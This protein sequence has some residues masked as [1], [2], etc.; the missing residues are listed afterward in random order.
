MWQCIKMKLLFFWFGWV[1]SRQIRMWVRRQRW[2]GG[3]YTTMLQKIMGMW[4]MRMCRVILWISKGMGLSSWLGSLRKKRDLREL[5]CALE[6]LWM[7]NSTLFACS[8]LQTMSPCRLFWFFPRLKVSFSPCQMFF[9]SMLSLLFYTHH[10]TC[11][12]TKFDE[13]LAE[14]KEWILWG[15]HLTVCAKI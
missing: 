15:I 11:Y 8:F 5:L 7:E 1:C 2:R 3:L 14:V 10:S 9:S 13:V 6:V 4:M 12:A